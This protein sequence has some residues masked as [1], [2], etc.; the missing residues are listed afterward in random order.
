MLTETSCIIGAFLNGYLI[1]M[2][3]YRPTFFV[4]LGF[5]NGFIFLSFFGESVMIQTVG[6]A[7]CGYGNTLH[8][9]RRTYAI[10][11]NP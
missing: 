1:K 6:Q 11:N 3:G 7:L 2:F 10:I 5:M 4:S 8:F 9:S